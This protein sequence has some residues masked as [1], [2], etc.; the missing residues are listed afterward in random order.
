MQISEGC[1]SSKKTEI[2]YTAGA[3]K[4]GKGFELTL[5][6]V[7]SELKIKFN[8]NCAIVASPSH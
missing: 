3:M 6:F 8:T 4:T 1:D 2:A 7:H 5:I